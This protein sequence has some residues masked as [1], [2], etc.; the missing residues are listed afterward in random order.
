MAGVQGINATD[1]CILVAPRVHVHA[2]GELIE[3][4]PSSGTGLTN[5]LYLGQYSSIRVRSGR[6]ADVDVRSTSLMALVLVHVNVGSLLSVS[7]RSRLPIPY[8]VLT[9]VSPCVSA[10]DLI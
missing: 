7:P 9:R 2:S 3:A 4:P 5:Y 8:Q 1:L 10:R 6:Y